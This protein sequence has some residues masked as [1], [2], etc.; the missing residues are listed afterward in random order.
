VFRIASKFKPQIRGWLE[1]RSGLTRDFV[2]PTTWHQPHLER[3]AA[4]HGRNAPF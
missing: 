2:L 1:A 4:S 3:F